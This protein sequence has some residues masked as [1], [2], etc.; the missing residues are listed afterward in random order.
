MSASHP[1][2]FKNYTRRCLLIFVAI[3]CGTG[4]MV[5]A[6]FA[7]VASTVRI[8]LILAIAIFN[9]GLVSGFLMHLVSERKMVYT[10]LIFTAIFFIGLMGLTLFAHSDVPHLKGS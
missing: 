3:V 8:A 9:A 4:L 1:E 7:S 2:S 5:A 10:V 6:S